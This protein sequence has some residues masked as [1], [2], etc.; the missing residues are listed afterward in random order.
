MTLNLQKPSAEVGFL[1]ST[2]YCAGRGQW[3]KR[4]HV[5]FWWD[6]CCPRWEQGHAAVQKFPH[7]IFQFK[8]KSIKQ[9][10][11]LVQNHL[12]YLKLFKTFW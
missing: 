11:W 10:F 4:A 8:K 6:V 7:L 3:E 12:K 2:Q 9:Y 5:A 1:F